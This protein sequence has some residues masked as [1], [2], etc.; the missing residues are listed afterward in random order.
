MKSLILFFILMFLSNSMMAQ[1]QIIKKKISLNGRTAE[2]FSPKSIAGKRAPV[3]L[4]LH[5]GL[6]DS[7]KISSKLEFNETLIRKKVHGVFLN[8]TDQWKSSKTSKTWNSGECCGSAQEKNIDDLTYIKSAIIE[9]LIK[10][11]ASRDKVSLLGH[12]NGAMMSLHFACENSHLV[13]HLYLLG[14]TFMSDG[15]SSLKGVNTHFIHGMKDRIVPIK[16]GGKG[17]II[18]GKPFPSQK[19]VQ[20]ILKSA[21]VKSIKITNLK[22]GEHS[23]ESLKTAAKKEKGKTLGQLFIP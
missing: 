3:I 19:K 13:S 20:Q 4:V 12:S 6:S 8:G 14:G 15:C 1:E 9:L 23:I 16:G 17:M 21:G 22:N 10:G 18:V 11:Y 5:G 2:I 7:K